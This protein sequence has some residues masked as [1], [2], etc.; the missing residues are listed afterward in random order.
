MPRGS[1]FVTA[2]FVAFMVLSGAAGQAAELTP[3]TVSQDELDAAIARHHDQRT[4]DR[5]RVKAMLQRDDIRALAQGQGL[6]LRRA[7]A[8]VDT[9]ED[10]ELRS[11]A[12]QVSNIESGLQGGDVYI[13]LSLIALLLII[14]IVILLAD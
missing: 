13:R 11:L 4:A 2:T 12:Q 10:S 7:E 5:D 8:A 9:L 6:D 3:P 14:I 1:S